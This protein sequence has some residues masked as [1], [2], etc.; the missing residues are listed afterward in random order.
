MGRGGAELL[1][2]FSRRLDAICLLQRLLRDCWDYLQ[3]HS[4]PNRDTIDETYDDRLDG[5]E[6]GSPLY[7]LPITRA[8]DS[9]EIPLPI[10]LHDDGTYNRLKI[11]YTNREEEGSA[12]DSI[13]RMISCRSSAT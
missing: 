2:P 10:Q 3:Y 8:S 12:V 7:H 6:K 5:A 11:P 13:A 1:D 4:H 9:E